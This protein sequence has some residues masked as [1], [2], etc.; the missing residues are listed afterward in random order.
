LTGQDET[1]FASKVGPKIKQLLIKQYKTTGHLGFTDSQAYDNP[2]SA[3]NFMADLLNI[4][5]E[6][7]P[8]DKKDSLVEQIKTTLLTWGAQ[9]AVEVDNILLHDASAML[10]S[11]TVV[12]INEA[13]SRNP[14]AKD[15]LLQPLFGA[16][17]AMEASRYGWDCGVPAD[18]YIRL[19]SE[20][21]QN[22]V[23]P[24][25]RMI[26][27]SLRRLGRKNVL[28]NI[29]DALD[30]N[31]IENLN[32]II[33]EQTTVEQT[34]T[35]NIWEFSPLSPKDTVETEKIVREWLF[36]RNKNDTGRNH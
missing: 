17:M 27:R 13:L 30:G 22:G 9:S 31:L 6:E 19:Q 23:S 32:K 34:K 8:A 7:T 26:S 21:S 5:V 33:S 2:E 18:N 25:K 28:Q 14:S 10:T 4:L 3:F 20:L 11:E 12:Q 35:Q 29:K 24:N 15:R 36:R 16:L 1:E